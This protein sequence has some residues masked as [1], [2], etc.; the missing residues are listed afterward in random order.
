M[1]DRTQTEILARELAIEFFIGMNK[2]LLKEERLDVKENVEK[3]W[4]Q[5]NSQAERILTSLPSHKE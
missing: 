1:C 5:W 2:A 4:S 3:Y